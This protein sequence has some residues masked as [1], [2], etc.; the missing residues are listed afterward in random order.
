ML[1]ERVKVTGDGVD[2]AHHTGG[3]VKNGKL[4][5]K[6]FLRPAT[7]LMKWPVVFEDLADGATVAHPVEE[8]PP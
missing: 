2:V 6:E 7:K 1:N 4:R 8:T 3:A 5:P